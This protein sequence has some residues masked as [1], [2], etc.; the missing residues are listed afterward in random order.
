[1]SILAVLALGLSSV[2][3]PADRV[4][5]A[6]PEQAAAVRQAL[7]GAAAQL[8]DPRCQRVLSEFRDQAGRT[9]QENLALTGRTA[10]GFIGE[11]FFYDGSRFPACQVAE[12]EEVI[13][14]TSPGSRV[15]FVCGGRFRDR[16]QRM[17]VKGEMV[18]IHEALHGLGLAENPPSSEHITWAVTRHC[19]H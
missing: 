13:A 3:A 2:T 17:P 7:A 18:L 1:M 10:S 14:F 9:L 19:A 6:D 15:V 12:S 11:L 8:D 16:H 4:R 5:L